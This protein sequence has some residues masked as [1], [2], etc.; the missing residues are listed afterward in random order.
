MNKRTYCINCGSNNHNPKECS[1][2]I[3]SYGV[4]LVNFNIDSDVHANKVYSSH[5]KEIYKSQTIIK[6][7]PSYLKITSTILNNIRFLMICRKHSLG[8]VE[9]VR[10]RY[11]V[12]KI[13][14]IVSLFTQMTDEEIDKIK[15]SLT[16][17]DDQGFKYLWK[18]LWDSS[19]RSIDSSSKNKYKLLKHIGIDGPEI[20][21]DFL[22][23][24]VEPEFDN[25]E[26][27][28]P[29]GRRQPHESDIDCAIREFKEETG[30][31]DE[32]FKV[33][34]EIEPIIELLTGT[35]GKAYKHVYYVAELI[36]KK[37]PQNGI[38][39]SQLNEI[40]DIAFMNKDEAIMTLRKYHVEKHNIV[41]SLQYFYFDRIFNVIKDDLE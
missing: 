3:T 14:H 24:N 34:E 10:G 38:T 21:L 18:D 37:E 20:G 25:K 27:G 15:Y 4:I 29:K 33:I 13:P 2:P 17:D 19:S 40:G 16:L 1:Q 11:E 39:Q 12:C 26:W 22:V 31:E 5:D 32:D 7:N 35:N 30:Y 28:F 23:D 9:F 41:H 8:Y 6:N 36:N